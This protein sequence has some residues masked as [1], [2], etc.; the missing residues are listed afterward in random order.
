MG[1]IKNHELKI[2]NCKKNKII[3]LWS[4]VLGLWPLA[5]YPETIET[6]YFKVSICEGC[7]LSSFAE[8]I[9]ATGLF[10]LDT[11]SKNNSDIR[12][13]IKEGIDSLFLEVCDVLNINLESYRGSLVVYPDVVEVSKAIS[14][15]AQIVEANLPSVYIPSHNTIYISFNDATAGMLAHEMAH[16]V[17]STYFVVAPPAKVQEILA[18]YVEYS[19]RKKMGS[20]P[21]K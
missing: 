6:K 20:L 15:S 18:G 3:F 17:I 5:C 13:V 19:I 10:R 9:N 4:L 12:S 8:K 11:L 16:A 2:K 1:K 21:Q 7:S 14:G